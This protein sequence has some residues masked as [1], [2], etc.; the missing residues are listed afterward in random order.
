[1][2][3]LNATTD[4]VQV[5]LGGAVTTNQLQCLSSYRDITTTAYTPGRTVTNTN[6]TT[7][8]NLVPAPAAST[9]RVVDTINIYNSD[10]AP[11]TVTVKFDANATEYILWKASLNIGERLEYTEG[12]GW[13]AFTSSGSL[14]TTE[15]L[16]TPT[17]NQLNTVVLAS[18]VVNADAVANTLYDVTGFSFAVVTA[19]VYWF[20]FVVDY[21][22]A[23]NTTGSRW[24]INGPAKTRLNYTQ[25]W[26]LAA[27]TTTDGTYDEYEFPAAS[28][29]TTPADLV[30][31]AI[32]E[33]FITPSADGTVIA[34]FA[35]E[36]TV[37]AITA[38][39]GSVLQWMRVI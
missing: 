32:I 13:R 38:K 34:R 4:N 2:I 17:V 7:D 3:I 5:V 24:T 12:Q 21:T 6:S 30:G 11:S 15:T 14:K 8:V 10:T 33:G 37:S 16:G 20:R 18:D 23:A 19:Q 28:N 27:T 29:T 26:S 22:S 36:I 31:V 9:Q 35:S 1:M 25:R 39:A